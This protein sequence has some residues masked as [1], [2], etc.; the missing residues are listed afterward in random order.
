[1]SS[2]DNRCYT[3]MLVLDLDTAGLVNIPGAIVR[4]F[5]VEVTVGLIYEYTV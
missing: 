5:G 4:H 3:G 1:V 2:V